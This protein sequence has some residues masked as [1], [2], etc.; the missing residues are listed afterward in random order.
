MFHDPGRMPPEPWYLPTVAAAEG[1]GRA[2]Y[3]VRVA[4]E[5]APRFDSPRG[6]VDWLSAEVGMEYAASVRYE[7]VA[8]DGMTMLKSWEQPSGGAAAAEYTRFGDAEA[9][10][11][12]AILFANAA[13]RRLLEELN[14]DVNRL[15][16][17]CQPQNIHIQ[18]FLS[19]V[20][21]K[22]LTH[23]DSTSTLLYV[24]SGSKS[25]W[26]APPNASKHHEQNQNFLRFDPHSGSMPAGHP[27]SH[28]WKRLDMSP[29]S[30]GLH[31]PSGYWH[32]IVS[33]EGTLAFGIKCKRRILTP[34]VL[35]LVALPALWIARSWQV[36][37][38]L[39]SLTIVLAGVTVHFY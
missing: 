22:S 2:A 11:Y 39:A 31:I 37:A 8:E 38:L 24:A 25:V 32:S 28:V 34:R 17:F 10:P 1:L 23:R 3:R 13:S 15:N 14:V 7:G 33:V 20:A 12:S 16:F 6:F 27:L 36:R 21:S 29:G 5:G 35:F 26:I 30:L 19:N 9:N 4:D 18:A